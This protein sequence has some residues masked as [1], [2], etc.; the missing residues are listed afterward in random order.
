MFQEAAKWFLNGTIF[1]I[2]SLSGDIIIIIPILWIRK[3][4]LRV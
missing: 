2:L 1:N 3:W 4:K